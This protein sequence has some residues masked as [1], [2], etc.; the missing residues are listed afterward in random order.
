VRHLSGAGCCELIQREDVKPAAWVVGNKTL[1]AVRSLFVD[2]CS[3]KSSSLSRNYKLGLSAGVRVLTH[4]ILTL[5]NMK[6]LRFHACLS[7]GPHLPE[8]KHL[9]AE[10]NQR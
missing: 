2:P 5:F 8:K 7:V 4:E 9:H 6:E 3:K 10:R 1:A